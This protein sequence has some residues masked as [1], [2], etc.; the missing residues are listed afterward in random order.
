MPWLAAPGDE[1]CQLPRDT[2][3]R[4]RGVWDSREALP[5]LVVDEVEDTEA[6]AGGKLVVNEGERPV[7]IRL[8]LH[9]DRSPGFDCTSTSAPLPHR[10]FL[11]A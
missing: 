3:S 10:Q 9:E 7:G 2:P 5:G 1:G 11:L 4:D 8:R 6:S